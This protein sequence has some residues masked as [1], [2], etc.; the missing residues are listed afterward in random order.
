MLRLPRVVKRRKITPQQITPKGVEALNIASSNGPIWQHRLIR[1]YGWYN[2]TANRTVHGLANAGYLAKE[3]ETGPRLRCNFALTEFGAQ[4]GSRFLTASQRMTIPDSFANL[5][6]GKIVLRLNDLYFGI[7]SGA[8]FSC[9]VV[10]SRMFVD[11]IEGDPVLGIGVR[12]CP[13]CGK[14]NLVGSACANCGMLS[15]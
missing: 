5:G 1:E 9:P 11:S 10:P 7:A 8:Y 15:T 13:K 12:I 6:G 3:A 2:Q 14:V 4:V